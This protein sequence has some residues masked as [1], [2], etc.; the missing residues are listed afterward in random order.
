MAGYKDYLKKLAQA[1]EQHSPE[2]F[3]A[4]ETKITEYPETKAGFEKLKNDAINLLTSTRSSSAGDTLQGEFNKIDRELKQKTDPYTRMS[5]EIE[6]YLYRDVGINGIFEIKEVPDEMREIKDEQGRLRTIAEKWTHN[7]IDYLKEHPELKEKLSPTVFMQKLKEAREAAKEASQEL[8]AEAEIETEPTFTDDESSELLSEEFEVSVES[9]VTGE[10]EDVVDTADTDT[11]D[12]DKPLEKEV[13]PSQPDQ[14]PEAIMETDVKAPTIKGDAAAENVA[15]TTPTSAESEPAQ[16]P[17]VSWPQ[18][19]RPFL[20]CKTQQADTLL[21]TSQAPPATPLSQ[22][23]DTLAANMQGKVV[24]EEKNGNHLHKFTFDSDQTAV[25][26]KGE[27]WD[28]FEVYP[29]DTQ[30]YGK[31]AQIVSGIQQQGIEIAMRGGSP[32]QRLDLFKECMQQNPPVIIKDFHNEFKNYNQA[33]LPKAITDK[34]EEKTGIADSRRPE[35][36]N[37]AALK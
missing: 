10:F 4:L 32:N 36:H 3:A 17:A 19:T 29:K 7:F 25:T 31:A 23:C 2:T 6:R 18:P 13:V 26:I 34:Y 35:S 15:P 9:F 30:S 20:D 37:A 24:H 28:N 14:M 5:A 16:K 1:I 12:S 21:D 11:E 33:D 22:H 8:V 27:S